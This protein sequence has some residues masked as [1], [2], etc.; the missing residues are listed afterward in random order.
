MEEEIIACIDDK[1]IKFLHT[2]QISKYVFPL[3]R[4]KAHNEGISHL[5][6]RFFIIAKSK[7]SGTLYLVQKRSQKK[8]SFPGYYTD[9]ASGHV[10]YQ[11]NL[12]LEDIKDDALRELEEEFGIHPK[13][14]KNVKFYTLSPE[15]DKNITEIAYIFLGLV[16]VDVRLTPNE[17]ELDAANSRFYTEKELKSIL[18]EEEAIDYSKEIWE[19]LININIYEKFENSTLLK[20]KENS[21]DIALFIGRFQPLHHGHIYIINQIL[22]KHKK[23]KIGIGS[24]Q[25]S[26]KKN[27]PFS[28]EERVEFIKTALESRNI[29]SKRYEIYKIPDI[30]NAQK[31]VDHVI[32][33]VGEIDIVYSNSDWVRELFANKGFRVSK[34]IGIFK[35]KFNGTNIRNLIK[36]GDNSWR[37][38]LPKE[39]VNL[40]KKFDG[41]ERIR[42]LDNGD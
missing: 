29:N 32:S 12:R 41:I 28:G 7:D 34:K 17:V 14:V 10:K 19:E 27:D 40:I 18:E 4:S 1:N 21:S 20:R 24:S 31:W 13:N 23:I 37:G 30:F 38:L 25:L 6:I 8:E 11:K 2:G 36:E 42:S 22:R 3:K 35:K 9:S 5:I 15:K 26:Y 39:I 16:D 33:I